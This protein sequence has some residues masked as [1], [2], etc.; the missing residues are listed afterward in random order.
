MHTGAA[1]STVTTSG[2]FRQESNETRI[3]KRRSHKNNAAKEALKFYG[4]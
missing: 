1:P 4:K 3:K 2:F